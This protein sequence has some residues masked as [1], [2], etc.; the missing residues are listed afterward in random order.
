MTF[1]QCSTEMLDADEGGFDD[2]VTSTAN[3]QN[4]VCLATN[5]RAI[6]YCQPVPPCVQWNGALKNL[7]TFHI[8]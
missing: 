5:R 6:W 1:E 8:V 2:Q 3:V 4:I 7:R